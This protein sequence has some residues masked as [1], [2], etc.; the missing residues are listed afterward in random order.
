MNNYFNLKDAFFSH[1]D[2]SPET[3]PLRFEDVLATVTHLKAVSLTFIE[4]IDTY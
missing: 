4:H 1:S 2:A 3:P